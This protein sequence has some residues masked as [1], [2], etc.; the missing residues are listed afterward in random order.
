MSKT[1]FL[2]D[3]NAPKPNS[4]VIAV[5]AVVRNDKHQLLLVQRADN[6]F[7]ALPGGAQDHGESVTQA[8]VREVEEE[9]GIIVEV[10]GV[11][12]IY[13]D[14]GHVIAYDNGEV[15][16]EFSICFHAEPVGG[17]I[18]TS[19]ETTSVRWIRPD[20]IDALVVHPS[21][22]LRIRH[23]LSSRRPHIG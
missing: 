2:N 22:L 17:T 1:D 20:M 16:Q 18:R 10:S 12:G 4:L 13:S 11:S 7:W 15:R 5:G 6:G 8:V 14:P 3:P 9:T 19:D 23:G 21:M